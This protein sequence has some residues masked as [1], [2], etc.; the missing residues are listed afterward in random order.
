M[1]ELWE[2]R[3][4]QVHGRTNKEREQK[5]KSRNLQELKKLFEKRNEVRPADI[6]LFPENKEE[7]I[8]KNTA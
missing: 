8:E 2:I 7:F 1:I 6:V 4:G 3:N 5:R